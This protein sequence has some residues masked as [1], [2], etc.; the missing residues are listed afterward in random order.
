MSRP[1]FISYARSS[2]AVHAQALAES[3]GE[4]SSIPTRSRMVIG[5]RS[6]CSKGCLVPGWW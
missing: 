2:N 6:I 5:F 4:F 3:L 1:V